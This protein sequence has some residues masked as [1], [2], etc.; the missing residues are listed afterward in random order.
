M[1]VCDLESER[2]FCAQISN[3]HVFPTGG[4]EFNAVTGDT[5][6]ESLRSELASRFPDVSDLSR[7]PIVP[8]MEPLRVRERSL[9]DLHEL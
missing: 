7:H 3:I 8:A 2:P 5:L 4:N 6:T 9:W 1:R